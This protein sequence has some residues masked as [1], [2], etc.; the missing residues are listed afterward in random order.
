MVPSSVDVM[1]LADGEQLLSP[2]VREEREREK[3]NERMKEHV[4]SSVSR[5]KS[6]YVYRTPRMSMLSKQYCVL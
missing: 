2:T 4:F 5:I 6:V 3:K 1:Y